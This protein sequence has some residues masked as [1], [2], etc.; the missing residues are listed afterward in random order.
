MSNIL[1]KLIPDLY[2]NLD[3]VS[4]ELTGFLPSVARNSSAVRAALGESVIVPVSTAMESGN[5]TPSMT[6]PEPEDFT[7]DNVAIQITKSRN[8]SFGLTGEEFQGVN[9]GVGANYILG[10]NIKQAV[11]TLV[12]EMEKDVAIEAAVGS[13]RAFGTAGSTP[14]ASDLTDAAHIKKILDDNGAPMGGRSLIIDSTAGVNLRSLTQLTNVGDAGTNMTLRQGELLNLFG[15]SIKES[16][17]IYNVAQSSIE[18]VTLSAAE[19]GANELTIKAAT[20]GSLKAGDVITIAGDDNKY[21]VAESNSSLSAGNKIKIAKPGLLH[22][23][24]DGSSVTVVAASARNI[25]FT[26]NAIQLVTRAP[27]LPAGRDAAIDSYILTDSRS[28]MAFEVRVYQGYRKMRMEVA[29][30]WGV[31]VIKPEHVATLLG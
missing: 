15:F 27:A 20:S 26:K 23:V 29:C 11:R 25:A 10:E 2:Q 14:F 24:A 4:R 31:K 3:E 12:N 5:V 18:G 7:M 21:V 16:A 13:S 30:A 19:I 6:V 8:V 22:A 28:G 1:T 17:G 9:N